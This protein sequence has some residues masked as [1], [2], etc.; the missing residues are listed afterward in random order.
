MQFLIENVDKFEG[1]PEEVTTDLWAFLRDEKSS[2]TEIQLTL[3]ILDKHS[4]RPSNV[5][6]K[7]F[8]DNRVA[9]WKLPIG[10]LQELVLRLVMRVTSCGDTVWNG[11]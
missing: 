1:S 5:V 11:L 2:P 7:P 9:S 8:S 4:V 3:E 10:T 6:S